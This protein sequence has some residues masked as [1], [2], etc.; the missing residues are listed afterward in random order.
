MNECH[1]LQHERFPSR[2]EA[3]RDSG[4]AY[5]GVRLVPKRLTAQRHRNLRAEVDGH[6]RIAEQ[7]HDLRLRFRV[8][9][10]RGSEALKS[11]DYIELSRVIVL[12]RSV[13]RQQQ[14]L[15]KK[16][17][18]VYKRTVALIRSK[19]NRATRRRDKSRA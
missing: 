7:V 19:T 11:R 13:I 2:C 6:R 15:I 17:E 1:E 5:A 8:L 4:S 10:Q 16:S 3:D 9:H 14:A 18:Q 12:E